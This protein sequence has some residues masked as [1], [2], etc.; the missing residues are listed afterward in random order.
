MQP[1]RRIL[2]T[3]A[4]TLALA[5]G[6]TAT[7]ATAHTDDPTTE[8]L[9]TAAVWDQTRIHDF[10]FTVDPDAYT[11][12]VRTFLDTGDKTWL[13][14]DVTIDG[15]TYPGA[16]VRLKGNSSLFG[17]TPASDPGTL[18]WL[19]RLDKFT[20]QDHQGYKR[21]IVR[22]NYTES[23]LNEALAL[24]LLERAGLATTKHVPAAFS[25]NGGTPE[26]RL[27]IQD[28]DKTFDREHFGI[29]GEK[30]GGTLYKKEFE[31]DFSYLGT[32]PEAYT[33]AW[34]PTGG[35]EDNWDPLF[36]FLD[37]LNNSSDDQFAAQLETRLDVETFAAYLAVQDL[38]LNWDDIDGP[39]QNGYFRWTPAT[40]RFTIVPWD[41]NLSFGIIPAPPKPGALA[42]VD[43]LPETMQDD[44][45]T[46]Q[47]TTWGCP[48]VE[49]ALEV[50]AFRTRYEQTFYDLKAELYDSGW[51]QTALDDLTATITGSPLIT[52]T[53]LNRDRTQIQSVLTR[54][55]LPRTGATDPNDPDDPP[56]TGDDCTA[57][58]AVTG[59][60]GSGWQGNL[61]I[62]AGADP[63]DGW[64]L[65]WT[66][67]GT[68]TIDSHWNAT[69]TTTGT[70]VTATDAG[71]NGAIAAGQTT[72]AWGFI[73]AGPTATP[74]VT[75]TAG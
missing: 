22:T 75:C 67:P 4:T 23:S 15:Q 2:A 57:A 61:Q 1:M 74:P 63:V 51:A 36:G 59:D 32:D 69:V 72:E 53:A 10:Q 12:M 49:R 70:T 9:Q 54:D 17:L 48:C 20:E 55:L 40:D 33:D 68:Q 58:I 19:I 30:D 3:V 31:L 66:W 35:D 7:P 62:T 43:R 46:A 34:E 39:G 21:F 13:E 73:A 65:T 8:P 18:P 11:A 16:G 71:W 50:P 38:I 6:L 25:V 26:L 24:E 56:P 42:T 5:T 41:H 28:L 60:W 47:R 45:E 27:V 37:W 52:Q 44:F 29:D 64:T 14:A